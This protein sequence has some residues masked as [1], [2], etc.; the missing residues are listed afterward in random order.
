M[1]RPYGSVCQ[2]CFTPHLGRLGQLGTLTVRHMAGYWLNLCN[3]VTFFCWYQLYHMDSHQLLKLKVQFGSEILNICTALHCIRPT[4]F[5]I[6]QTTDQPEN[7]PSNWP[8]NRPTNPNNNWPANG[9]TKQSVTVSS[10]PPALHT[11]TDPGHCAQAAVEPTPHLDQRES[12]LV[13][14][15]PLTRA[16]METCHSNSQW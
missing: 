15:S 10:L 13:T 3:H 4:R 7:Q 5:S 11:Y 9:Q 12:V 6:N 16:M 14:A 8:I 2:A 1:G